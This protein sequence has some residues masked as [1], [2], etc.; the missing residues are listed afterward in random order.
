MDVTQSGLQVLPRAREGRPD[1]R[2]HMDTCMQF[3]ICNADVAVLPQTLLSVP[4]K[5][6]RKKKKSKEKTSSHHT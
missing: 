5:K 4:G 3:T 6:E 2:S 1:A